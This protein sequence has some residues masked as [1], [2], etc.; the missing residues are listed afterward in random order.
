MAIMCLSIKDIN[1]DKYG[2][3][4]M[5]TDGEHEK[6]EENKPYF[7]LMTWG[8]YDCESPFKIETHATTSTLD[9]CA[10]LAVQF[11]TIRQQEGW[12]M[13]YETLESYITGGG[14]TGFLAMPDDE[15]YVKMFINGEEV[16]KCETRVE[17]TCEGEPEDIG[18]ITQ[19]ISCDA[20]ICDGCTHQTET[21]N[22]CHTCWEA[23]E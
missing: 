17:C 9:L 16:P 8:M 22:L 13:F 18:D 21:G 19:C 7:E 12:D 1:K 11:P 6:A 5:H 4:T 20:H 3:L 14:C 2:V 23:E 15:R 10:L